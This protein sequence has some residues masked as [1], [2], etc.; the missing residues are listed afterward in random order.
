MT[1]FEL[2]VGADAFW[3]RARADMARARRRLLVQAM[4][5]EGD[6]AG[7]SVAQAIAASPADDRRVLVD[8]YSRW[9]IS[10][11]SVRRPAFMQ[12]AWLRDEVRAT[13]A[14]FDGLVG[15]G[16]AVRV[17]NRIG[18]LKLNYPARNHKKLIVTD[19]VAYVGGINFSDHNFAWRD[20]MLR[21]EGQAAA[22]CLADDFESTFA[23]APKAW[24]RRLGELQLLSLDGRSNEQGFGV[25]IA[26][27]EAA[28]R[29]ITVISP[30][31][32]FPFTDVLA[33]AAARGVAVRLITP[34]AN[35]KPIIRDYLLAA[36]A[37]AGFEIR[38]MPEMSHLKGLLVDGERLVIGSANFDFASLAAEEELVAIIA[39][40]ALIEAFRNQII[41]P[42]LADALP[43]AAYRV[44]ALRGRLAGLGLKIAQP[45]ARSARGS[46]R[47]VFDW[48]TSAA[49][50]NPIRLRASAVR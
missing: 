24:S 11:N 13:K 38:L 10:D 21:L 7:Q 40:P 30:Y 41:A 3:R 45:V 44:S 1:G 50:T 16:V 12:P 5:F 25:V 42:A 8:D 39:D 9:V 19:D 26:L 46:R 6:A 49:Q 18:P 37:R 35:N 23:G 2:L 29:E 47:G 43:A 27:I 36:A 48:P 17:T 32:T 20:F 31:L 33:R 15:A 34:L 4:T 14:M 28:T 22:D